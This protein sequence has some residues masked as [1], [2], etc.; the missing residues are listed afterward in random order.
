MSA[1]KTILIVARHG[2]TFGPGDV[3]TRVGGRT[4]LPL[5]ESGLEQGRKLGRHLA[6]HNLIPDFIFTSEMQRTIQTAAQACVSMQRDIPF[7]ELTIFNEIDY[8]PDEN[9]PEA[10]VRARVGEEAIRRWDE[11]AIAPADWIVDVPGLKQAWRDFGDLLLE[12]FRGQVVLLVT[13]NGIA[14]FADA[15]TSAGQSIY[16]DKGM[17]LGTGAFGVFE[18]D[19]KAWTC[20]DWNVKP[21]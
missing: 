1:T 5:V 21:E 11:Q 20:T 12:E 3:V 15:L 8:G 13:H 19:G 10:E 7:Q 17:K 9:R 4:D 16:G 2:N 18:H 6:A 14:R